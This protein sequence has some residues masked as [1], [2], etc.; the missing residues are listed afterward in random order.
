MNRR[1]LIKQLS[2]LP[3]VGGLLGT[4]SLASPIAKALPGPR[5]DYYKGTRLTHLY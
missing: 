4:E 1:K 2:A 5:R 3:I